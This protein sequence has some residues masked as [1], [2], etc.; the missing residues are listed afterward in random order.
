MFPSAPILEI[1]NSS[2]T[3]LDLSSVGAMPI[4]SPSSHPIKIGLCNNFM[5]VSPW[6]N[7][8][9]NRLQVRVSSRPLI[10]TI[11]LSIL[12]IDAPPNDRSRNIG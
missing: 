5:E 9:D 8:S 3:P 10:S 12:L 6:F 1:L 2:P 7:G 11:G 4:R